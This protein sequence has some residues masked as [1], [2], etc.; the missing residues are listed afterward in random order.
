MK[1]KES[2]TSILKLNGIHFNELSFKR[3]DSTDSVID[4]CELTRKIVDIDV[5][6]FT[7]ELNF[8]LSTSIFEMSISLEGKFNIVCEDALM[9][10]RLKK[11]NTISI[12]FPYI[13]SEVTL[14]TS[15][16]EMTPVIIPPINI[17]KLIDESTTKTADKE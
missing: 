17:N 15:Q 9:K 5:D 12:L 1:L 16:P 3:R 13:R 4:D 8:K 11:N 7:V 2:T 6:N 10:E 14:L